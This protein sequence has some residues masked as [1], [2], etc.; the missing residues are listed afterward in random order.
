MEIYEPAEDSRFFAEFLKDYLSNSRKDLKYLDVGTGSGILVFEALNF[1]SRQNV[2]ACDINEKAVQ[3]L[4]EKGI[5]AICSNLFSKVVGK[6]DLITFNAP[7][8]PRDSREPKSSRVATTGGK[9]GDEISIKFLEEVKNYLNDG[10][11][12]FLLISSLT[13][14]DKINK[15]GGK[16]VAEKPLWM[17]KLLIIQIDN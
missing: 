4:K 9:Q 11:I 8:L 3:D 7:Y 1:L 16:V 5:N 14:R 10:G 6:F 2:F 15:F 13:P 12:A 17:E